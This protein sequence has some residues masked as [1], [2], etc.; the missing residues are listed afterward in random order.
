MQSN[1]DPKSGHDLKAWIVPD[2]AAE[3]QRVLQQHG[4]STVHFHHDLH[5]KGHLTMMLQL[6]TQQCPKLLWIRLAG[7]C[8]GTGNKR[9]AARVHHLCTLA[10]QQRQAGNMLVVE[11]NS[12]S[13]SWNLLNV[14]ALLEG[15]SVSLHSWCRHE[16]LDNANLQ[17]CNSIV[18]LATNFPL[19]STTCQC[20]ADTPHVDSKQLGRLKDERWG[21]VLFGVVSNAIHTLMVGQQHRQPELK[22]IVKSAPLGVGQKAFST[23]ISNSDASLDK[24]VLDLGSSRK[25]KTVRFEENGHLPL[26]ASY[27]T[28]QALRRKAVLAAGH[29]PM[30][31]QKDLEDH[32]DDC[33]ESL[34][35][36][37]EVVDPMHR[38]F[39][40]M[41]S[42]AQCTDAE[43][44]LF[45]E[46]S[47]FSFG[48]G[49]WLHGSNCLK[50][51]NQLANRA[52]VSINEM[53]TFHSKLKSDYGRCVALLEI[54]GGLGETSYILAKYHGLKAGMNFDLTVGFDLTSSQD[55]Q[56]LYVY[57]TEHEPLVIVM[58]P[59]CKGFSALQALNKVIYPDAWKKAYDEGVVM[60]ELCAALANIQLSAG[61]HFLV[62]QPSASKLFQLPSWQKIIKHPRCRA[63]EF[64]QCQTGLKMLDPPFLPVQKPTVLVASSETLMARFRGLKCDQKHQHANI[65]SLSAKG[66]HV[67]SREMQVWPT[68]LCRR[69][70]AGIADLV[71]ISVNGSDEQSYA[72]TGNNV[73]PQCPGCKRHRR[74]DDP[75]HD[76]GPNCRYRDVSEHKWECPA[77]VRNLPRPDVR[78]KLDHT[79]KWTV[80]GSLPEGLARERS[81]RH[82]RDARVPA[83]SEPTAE[84]RISDLVPGAAPSSGSRDV[85]SGVERPISA[86]ARTRDALIRGR[87]AM[88]ADVAAGPGRR[89]TGAQV[90]EGGLGVDAGTGPSEPVGEDTDP[91]NAVLLSS[92]HGRGL[93]LAERYRSLGRR[94]LE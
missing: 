73:T 30:R 68:A 74:K 21:K 81:G 4:F 25:L 7:P 87:R 42:E 40:L 62:E 24:E 82:P 83:S 28:E 49:R 29:K 37:L 60:A 50:P 75:E 55:V 19:A 26:D 76:R 5:S 58:A 94:N 93:T 41:T 8:A 70:A 77:C 63:V 64:D 17:P 78:H 16:N 12:R 11:A 13:Q 34:D 32:H 91:P 22:Y 84:T 6:L 61:R 48:S 18:Q 69:L 31:K 71:H 15:L 3:R 23:S 2:K 86:A 59:P 39:S 47:M 20:S 14:Q 1:L 9:D 52:K 79:C 85:P 51:M 65:T 33:G 72:A 67:C 27:P 46:I 44:E 80:A 54:F 45:R 35:S 53:D 92:S 89:S 88:S 43:Y 57:V 56:A 36:I 38:T 90:S 66:P 10:Q